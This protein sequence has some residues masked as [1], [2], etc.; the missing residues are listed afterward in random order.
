[1]FKDSELEAMGIENSILQM[2]SD[3]NYVIYRLFSSAEDK[4]YI[5]YPT[6]DNEGI[7]VAPSYIISNIKSIFCNIFYIFFISKIVI[8]HS[9]L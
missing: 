6:A 5:S 1:M 7:A 3:E 9:G 2:H 4:L 8:E